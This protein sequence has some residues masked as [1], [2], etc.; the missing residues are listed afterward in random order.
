[1]ISRRLVLSLLVVGTS[2][3]GCGGSSFSTSATSTPATSTNGFDGSLAAA[4]GACV[5]GAQNIPDQGARSTAQQ[6]C[7]MIPSGS[8]SKPNVN[9]TLANAKQVCLD[10]AQNIPD[11]GARSTAQQA[12]NM[13]P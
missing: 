13:I 10:G 12:C 4:K 1:M 11:Q 5:D 2:L 6:A 9:A 8:T 3:N 7:D